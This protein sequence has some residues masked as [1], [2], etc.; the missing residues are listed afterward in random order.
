M[1][2][3]PGADRAVACRAA[4]ARLVQPSFAACLRRAVTDTPNRAA[5]VG[6]DRPD[7]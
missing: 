7:R 4:K 2:D 6:A 1:G 3:E 5:T